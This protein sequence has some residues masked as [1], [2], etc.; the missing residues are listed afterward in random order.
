MTDFDINKNENN[1]YD[2]IKNNAIISS[3]HTEKK[4]I[5]KHKK[6]IKENKVLGEVSE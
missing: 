5:K 1:C 6:L 4:A 3:K 2:K